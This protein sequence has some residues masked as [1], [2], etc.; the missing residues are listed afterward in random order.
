MNADP[1]AILVVITLVIVLTQQVSLSKMFKV[2]RWVLQ[3][4]TIV[5]SNVDDQK[6]LEQAL[7]HLG[8]TKGGPSD[9]KDQK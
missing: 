6:Q 7:R 5:S 2:L 1:V 3:H 8:I 9:N 4:V